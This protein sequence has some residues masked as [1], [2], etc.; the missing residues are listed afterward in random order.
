[1]SAG[2]GYVAWGGGSRVRGRG[3]AATAHACLY[4]R[5]RQVRTQQ[6]AACSTSCPQHRTEACSDCKCAGAHR[7]LPARVRANLRADTRRM[8][9]QGGSPVEA[10]EGGVAPHPH[11]LVHRGRLSRTLARVRA[12]ARLLASKH[13][14]RQMHSALGLR[15]GLTRRLRVAVWDGVSDSGSRGLAWTAA[16][17]KSGTSACISARQSLTPSEE[18]TRRQEAAALRMPQDRTRRRR[19]SVEVRRGE[20]DMFAHAHGRTSV[21]ALACALPCALACSLIR[22]LRCGGGRGWTTSAT[23]KASPSTKSPSVS[24]RRASTPR[25]CSMLPS[26]IVRAYPYAQRLPRQLM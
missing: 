14:C 17:S 1:M 15:L 8:R 7:S 20:G 21:R 13:A 16:A 5:A 24:A 22:A 11:C 18:A 19:R 9:K 23:E 6:P 4:V 26:A 12:H 25:S 2:R 10:R 3:S